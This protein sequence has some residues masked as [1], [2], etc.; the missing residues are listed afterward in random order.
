MSNTNTIQAPD[1]DHLINNAYQNETG[2][3]E[4]KQL[5]ILFSPAFWVPF[6][7]LLKQ[8]LAYQ[9]GP[10]KREVR[11]G[12]GYID[13]IPVAEFIQTE[14]DHWN[15]PISQQT[16]IGD[17]ALF[18]IDREFT[19]KREWRL[20]SARGLV[21][22]AKQAV[23][24]DSAGLVT[25]IVPLPRKANNP[26]LK[27]LVL[28]SRWPNFNLS[29][30]AGTKEYL[31]KG[32]DMQ[33]PPNTIPSQ[34]WYIGASPEMSRPFQ[35]HWIAGPSK[36]NEPCN[37]SLGEILE[38]IL[39]GNGKLRNGSEVGRTF[40]FDE[41]RLANSKDFE[42][43][44][45][46][47]PPNWDDLCHQLMLACGKYEMP[48][49]LLKNASKAGRINTATLHSTPF[50]PLYNWLVSLVRRERRFPVAIIEVASSE[51]GLPNSWY[52]EH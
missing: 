21:L 8:A 9:C 33:I 6:E 30:T 11:V 15:Q 12:L 46:A 18:F 45:T 29:F 22:Q 1:I 3:G 32:Y 43:S 40:S 50:G 37:R 10:F 31:Q 47:S 17:A 25:P 13:K 39:V 34:G 5:A 23:Q 36:F 19:S 4:L 35:P 41:S 28:L 52:G 42:L 20:K 26:T 24:H 27:E 48:S 49:S 51:I 2:G 16:E 38:A 44:G 14:L 7:H